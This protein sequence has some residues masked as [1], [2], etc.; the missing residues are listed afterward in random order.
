MAADSPRPPTAQ[1]V[2]SG[3][4]GAHLLQFGKSQ[5]VAVLGSELHEPH[6]GGVGE[7]R[8]NAQAGEEPGGGGLWSWAGRGQGGPCTAAQLPR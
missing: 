7:L 3:G 6:V 1:P 8:G 4:R 5:R 2:R